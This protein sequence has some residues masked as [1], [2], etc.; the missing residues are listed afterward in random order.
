MKIFDCLLFF[1]F[2]FWG[3]VSLYSPDFPRTC[4]VDQATLEL[5]NPPASTPTSQVLGLSLATEILLRLRVK[6]E[7]VH[8]VPQH[9]HRKQVKQ[10]MLV[11]RKLVIQGHS[12][13]AMSLPT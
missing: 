8:I 12:K 13:L 9:Y 6:L 1:F 7:G 3:R 11:L 4:F 5:R 2:S 10:L